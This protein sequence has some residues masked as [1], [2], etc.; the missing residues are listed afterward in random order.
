[1]NIHPKK[2]HEIATTKNALREKYEKK[3]S[4]ES[5][6][7]REKEIIVRKIDEAKNTDKKRINKLKQIYERNRGMDFASILQGK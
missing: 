5:T 4:E 1:M 3:E 6:S 7:M 2:E